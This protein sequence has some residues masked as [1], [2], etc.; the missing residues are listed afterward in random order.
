DAICVLARI[1][2]ARPFDLEKGPLMKVCLFRAGSRE[3]TLV[4]FLHHIVCDGWSMGLLTHELTSLY[5]DSHRGAGSSLN[6]LPIQYADFA[7]WHRTYLKSGPL[8]KQLDYWRDR[9]G[10]ASHFLE[11]PLDRPRPVEQT[12]T[13]ATINFE[14]TPAITNDLKLL[15][16]KQTATLFMVL[17]A[18]FQLLLHRYSGQ[19]DLSVGAP[20][21]N[22]TTKEIEGIIGFFA[23]TLVLRSRFEGRESFSDLL[24]KIRATSLEAYAHQDLPFEMLVEALQPV[25]DMSRSPLFQVLFVLQNAPFDE[26]VLPNI[27]IQPMTLDAGKAHFDLTLAMMEVRGALQASIEFNTDLFDHTTISRLFGHFEALL[28]SISVDPDCLVSELPLLTEAERFQLLQEFNSTDREFDQQA[29]I[30]YLFERQA[31]K[32]PD[33]VSVVF[34][35]SHHT[36]QRLD[37]DADALATRL[38]SLGACPDVPIGI[39][40]ARS[41]EMVSGLIGILKSGG[42]YV[43]LDPAYPADRLAAM[44]EGVKLLVMHR[45]L[46][47]QL[48]S[49]LPLALCLD[50][51]DS[52]PSADSGPDSWGQRVIIQPENLC[53]V[54][55]TSGSTGRPKGVAMSHG[56]AVKMIAWQVASGNQG[57]GSRTLQ[58]ASLSFD[59]SFQEIFSTLSGGG[60]LVLISDE[61]RKDPARLLDAILTEQVER[62]FVPV[63][64]LQQIAEAAGDSGCFSLPLKEITTAGEQLKISREISSLFQRLPECRLFNHY[65]PSETHAATA[66]ALADDWTGWPEL[67]PIGKAIDNTAVYLL[68]RTMSPVPIGVV[69]EIF[70]GG[71]GLARGYLNQPAMTAERFIPDTYAIAPGSRLYASGDMGRYRSSGVV[72]FLGRSDHQLKIRGYRVEPGEI[73]AVIRQC[74]WI[75]QAIVVARESYAGDKRLAAYFVAEEGTQPDIQGLTNALKRRL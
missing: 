9:L 62:I 36:Y 57:P 25:R 48:P 70:I 26:L 47:E 12:F 43:P 31:A 56:A 42:A 27:D 41:L 40:L 20:I 52:I 61:S 3:F 74:S 45:Q 14:L 65:G 34:E 50:S 15:A 64:A 1:E 49:T 67:P 18:G 7:L 10:N 21:S 16:N 66:L 19:D 60:T 51:I 63:V 69:G 29:P 5:R 4:A 73:E 72:A 32:T 46:M 2:A 23:N 59:V 28:R 38:Q 13:G 58:F 54:V 39:C 30:H 35:G 37:L 8:A 33:A 44:I 68:D 11:M 53:Y 22:R 6:D 75:K 71:R 24:R 17:L 55:H